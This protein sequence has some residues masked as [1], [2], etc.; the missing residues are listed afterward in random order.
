MIET[1]A[2]HLAPFRSVSF[3]LV[4]DLSVRLGPL[5]SL[6]SASTPPLGKGAVPRLLTPHVAVHSERDHQDH[7]AAERDFLVLYLALLKVSSLIGGRLIS[8]HVC[9]TLSRPIENVK[10]THLPRYLLES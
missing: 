1:A 4:V 9:T 5:R 7:E 6:S 2:V 10:S 3:P 8:A